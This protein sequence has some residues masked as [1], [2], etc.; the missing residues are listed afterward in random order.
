M[1]SKNDLRHVFEALDDAEVEFDELMK[2]R[3][4]FVTY[5]VDKLASAKQIIREELE[6]Y[7]KDRA[8]SV[9]Q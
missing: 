3:E 6:S 4:W 7:D 9:R 8:S 5:V 1:L 2:E